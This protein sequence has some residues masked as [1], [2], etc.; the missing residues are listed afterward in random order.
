MG[1]C[2]N[3]IVIRKW[4]DNW[5]VVKYMYISHLPLNCFL[6]TIG[7][8]YEYSYGSCQVS[9][10]MRTWKALEK[11]FVTHGAQ[12]I[13]CRIVIIHAYKHTIDRFIC[14]CVLQTITIHDSISS[15][16]LNCF[17]TL[18]SQSRTHNNTF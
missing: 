14:T 12:H 8:P 5:Y 17:W 10:H 2:V 6:C 13:K 16:Y 9:K 1:V 15:K 3:V 11:G 18:L 4:N 7:I